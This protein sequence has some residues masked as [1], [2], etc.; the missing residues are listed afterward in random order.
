MPIVLFTARTYR[1]STLLRALGAAQSEEF[2]SSAI[3]FTKRFS[4][5]NHMGCVPSV[6]RVI[7]G[8]LR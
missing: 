4:V 2:S 7:I 8:E 3:G 6:S 1:V 5:D